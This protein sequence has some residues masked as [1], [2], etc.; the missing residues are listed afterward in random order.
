MVPIFMPRTPSRKLLGILTTGA[1][2]DV[3]KSLV[4]C[5]MLPVRF[6]IYICLYLDLFLLFLHRKEVPGLVANLLIGLT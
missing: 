3:E 1:Q 6:P 5:P 4:F 2:M